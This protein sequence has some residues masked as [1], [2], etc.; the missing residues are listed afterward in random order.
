[1]AMP[2]TRMRVVCTL[3]DTMLTFEPTSAVHQ[4]RLAG[5]GRADDGDEAGAC[6]CLGHDLS[7]RS[8][9]SDS[10]QPFGLALAAAPAARRL[11]ALDRDIDH[12]Y[13][14]VRRSF[15]VDFAIARQRQPPRLRPF[16]CKAVLGSRGDAAACWLS[17]S[18]HSFCGRRPPRLEAGIEDRRRPEAPP[19]H[20][21]GCWVR[22]CGRGRARSRP[23]ADVGPSPI[24]PA[25]ST[26]V[27]A[28]TKAACRRASSPSRSWGSGCSRRSAMASD[29][30]RSP[31]NSSRSLPWGTLLSGRG[32]G[33]AHRDGSAPQ[34]QAPRARSSGR[35][36]PAAPR[37]RRRSGRPCGMAM[38]KRFEAYCLWPFPRLQPAGAADGSC[39]KK[40]NSARP[41]RFFRDGTYQPSWSRSRVD[42][43]EVAQHQ[44]RSA[45]ERI[46][47]V[48]AHD[49]V[50]AGRNQELRRVVGR[51]VVGILEHRVAAAV[52]QL[53]VMRVPF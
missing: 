43:G 25:I 41:T 2:I 45:V 12:E 38:K 36:L 24:A 18:P 4:G 9:R 34:R 47:A 44:A 13:R 17:R 40:M 26:R 23:S 19:G 8:R 22:C 5:V 10:R 15:A 42:L 7:N 30:T 1:M 6:R 37:D 46:V 53:L 29:S 14:R 33:R 32:G 31:R 52:R 27:S 28:R 51:A 21:P 50:V 16:P 3:G 35:V 20:R 11:V 39:E 49:E 48:V